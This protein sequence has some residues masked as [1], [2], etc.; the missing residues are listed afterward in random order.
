ML[1]DPIYRIDGQGIRYYYQ[2]NGDDIVFAESVT[3]I[4]RETLVKGY[5]L[6]KW[7]ADMGYD[8]ARAYMM[9]AAAYGTTMHI[10]CGKLLQGIA[11]D[12]DGNEIE[13]ALYAQA[14]IDNV[15]YDPAWP[16]EMKKDLIAFV[17]WMKDYNVTPIVIEQVL[18]Y[19]RVGGAV[20]LICELDLCDRYKSGPKMHQPKP[21]AEIT[22]TRVMVDFKSGRKGFYES[23]EIQLHA[24]REMWNALFPDDRLELLFNWSP[25]EWR[26]APAYAFKD[27]TYSDNAVKWPILKQ[28]AFVK[29]NP[30]PRDIIITEG[31]LDPNTGDYEQN[32]RII[33]I[34]DYIKQNHGEES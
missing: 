3:S 20:D 18:M 26:T 5:G 28:L 10:L 27:Q 33:S 6:E 2:F 23:H 14:E 34:E 29:G 4:I 30:H 16:A 22:R 19:D 8:E 1:T 31:I 21:G 17:K 32:V 15:E 11:F 13:Q 9:K 7:Q 24:Y 25:K 12:L